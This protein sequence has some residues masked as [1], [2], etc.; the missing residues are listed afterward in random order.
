MKKN[1]KTIIIQ[2]IIVEVLGCVIF[3]LLMMKQNEKVLFQAKYNSYSWGEGSKEYEYKIYKNGFVVR[4][5]D[6]IYWVDYIG[7]I[8][9]IILNS[10]SI[11]I[12][13]EYYEPPYPTGATDC[14]ASNTKFYSNQE[15]KL[16]DICSGSSDSGYWKFY[17]KTYYKL[18]E[19]QREPKD[20]N[21]F[22]E[23]LTLTS[24]ELLVHGSNT[25]NIARIIIYYT[26]I[27]YYL[28]FIK[29]GLIPFFIV[30]KIKKT[31]Q[32]IE[33]KNIVKENTM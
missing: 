8:N 4:K 16:I 10:L 6:K 22:G 27:L 21:V 29:I 17:S 28:F 19:K 12:P 20:I 2:I 24:M 30:R 7:I 26:R 5:Y 9:T 3:S 14:G 11:K 23:T 33:A 25:S 18:R 31:N 1:I 15:E 32:T 13:N